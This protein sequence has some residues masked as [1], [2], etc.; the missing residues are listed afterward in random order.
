MQRTRSAIQHKANRDRAAKEAEVAASYDEYNKLRSDAAAARNSSDE[1]MRDTAPELES[2]ATNIRL[3]VYEEPLPKSLLQQWAVVFELRVPAALWALRSALHLVATAVCGRKPSKCDFEGDWRDYKPLQQ[4]LLKQ[5]S[6]PTVSLCSTTKLCSECHYKDWHIHPKKNTSGFLKQCG[7]NVKLA[8]VAGT[9][10]TL[11]LAKK[12][13]ASVAKLCT[14]QASQQY[15]PLQWALA[16]AQHTQ[17]EALV[18][19][20]EC[21]QQLALSEYNAYTALRAGHLLQLRHLLRALEMRSLS[22]DQES[23]LNQITQTL[24]QAGSA[25]TGSITTTAAATAATAVTDATA[26]SSAWQ[27]DS[28]YDLAVPPVST[29]FCAELMHTLNC[30]LDDAQG[31]WDAHGVLLAAITTAARALEL[32][33][34]AAAGS[35]AAAVLLRCRSMA[36]EQWAPSIEAVLSSA[37]LAG[38]VSA[39]V[40]QLRLKLVDVAAFA[41]LTFGACVGPHRAEPLLADAR[42]SSSIKRTSSAATAATARAAAVVWLR[43]VARVHDHVLLST[44]AD[45]KAAGSF[46]TAL[47]RRVTALTT[48]PEFSS[49]LHAAAAAAGGEALTKFVQQHWTAAAAAQPAV[50]ESV[51]AGLTWHRCDSPACNWYQAECAV[52]VLQVKYSI[53]TSFT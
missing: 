1:S 49:K 20:S 19:Q 3:A 40:Q 25:T 23:V 53:I 17:N 4:W 39:E 15:A 21:P 27:R 16:S 32:S 8:S 37:V 33:Q 12:P 28:H 42:N 43:S 2:Q 11:P 26:V 36:H 31:N 6:P 52:T 14:L 50:A 48:E 34:S 30:T 46:R 22:L 29:A 9:Q 41:A 13:A 45:R 7:Y 24:L 38:S 18:R 51:E 44:A 35:C 47:L 10:G 5:Q